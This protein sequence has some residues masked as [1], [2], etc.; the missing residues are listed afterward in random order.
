MGAFKVIKYFTIISIVHICI[1]GEVPTVNTKLGTITGLRKTVKF[2]G[3][4]YEVD[5]YL[6]IPYAEPPVND[7]RFEKPVPHG[8]FTGK[9]SADTFGAPCL[10]FSW[11]EE[12]TDSSEDCLFLNIYI[13]RQKPDMPSGHA[14]MFFIHG[15][16]FTL[17]TG[18]TYIGET[19]ASVGNVIVITINYRLGLFGFLDMDYE[20]A[21]GN[22][23]LWDQR[24]ALQWV[25][26]NIKTFGG[27]K[28][29]VTLF[30][31]SAGST[32]VVLQA[33]FPGN[34]GLFKSAIAE[35]GAITMPFTVPHN[36]ITPAIFFAE[37]LKC[38]VEDKAKMFDCLKQASS[39]SIMKVIVDAITEDFSSGSVRVTLNPSVD[40]EFIKR[41]PVDMYID[42]K[43][44]TLEEV[45]FFRSITFMNGINAAEG[46]VFV[47]MHA[48]P[49]N[50][51]QFTVTREKMNNEVLPAAA[52]LAFSYNRTITDALKQ[53]LLFEYTDWKCPDCPDSIRNQLIRFY[54]DVFFNV[55]AAELSRLHVNGTNAGSYVYN[56]RA[57]IK[58]HVYPTA[59]WAKEANHGDELGPV[60][61]FNF[62][63][64]RIL[65]ISTYTPTEAELQLSSKIMTYWSNFAKTG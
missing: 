24:L 22:F 6:G 30:G 59:S 40:G 7:R 21:T 42:A 46:A 2:Q 10:Q 18:N 41:R 56:F 45:E 35:S 64:N 57:H 16:G 58:G 8:G 63:Y 17:G 1:A 13:P 61:G 29:R 3:D 32:A 36:H 5:S 60:F 50:I 12:I 20:K 23:G 33:L 28:E 11:F 39:D 49:T 43:T 4:E 14:V 19:L 9:Y 38:N 34:K 62:K 31:E 65:G 26:E 55:P 48:D 27:D 51:E 54:S 53:L 25:H 37:K 47:I 44:E 15:G 52:A